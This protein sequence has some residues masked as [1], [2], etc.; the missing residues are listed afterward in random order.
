[1]SRK[2][3]IILLLLALLNFTHILDFMIMMPLGNY[4]IP[5][6]HISSQKFSAIVSAYSYSA[7]AAG[8]IASFFVDNHDR[9][10][11]LLFGYVGFLTGTILCGFA[12]SANLLIA[13]RIV[14]GLF[15]GLIG[16]QV[17]SIVA[18]TFLY[19]KIGQAMCY[20]MSAF[21]VASIVGMPS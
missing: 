18:D 11:I 8:I 6:F 9:K 4:L 13:A 10:K 16:A 21:S 2:E 19:E 15:G 17:L 20:L 14:A 5:Y 7:F 3:K 12:P 1:M